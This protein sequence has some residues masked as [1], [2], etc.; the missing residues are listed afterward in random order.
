VR[1]SHFADPQSAREAGR[2]LRDKG[3]IEDFYVANTAR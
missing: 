3:W 2:A 1:V